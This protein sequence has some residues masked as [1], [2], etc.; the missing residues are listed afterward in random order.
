VRKRPLGKTGLFVTELAIG[1]WGLSGD[2]Y[3]PVDASVARR[4][5]DRALEIG[6][7]VVDTA[8]AYGAGRM[9]ALV[10]DVVGKR[11]DV[12]VVTKGGT[13]R[14]TEPPRKRFAPDYLRGAVE[15]SLKRLRRDRIDVYL[16]HGPSAD[17]LSA[18]DCVRTMEDLVRE[19]KIGHWGVSAGDS[20]S[21]FAALDKGAEVLELAYNLFHAAELHR[22]VGDIMVAGAGVL[23][24]STLA[25]GLLAGEWSKERQFPEGDHRVDRWTRPELERRID[26]L[27]AIRFLVKDNVRSLRGAAVRYVL[28]NSIVTSA[29]LGPRT[30]EQLE[31]LVREVGGGPIYIPDRELAALP[32]ALAKVGVLL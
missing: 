6:V 32:R 2:A 5:L 19:G 18:T 27:D 25:Y 12:V 9:E 10:A 30:V 24:C 16:L 1:T 20:E 15:R 3:G 17:G 8:D 7:N 13:D 21:A 22:I 23:A 31:E 28:A 29:V 14:S 4:V 26:Q 11:D